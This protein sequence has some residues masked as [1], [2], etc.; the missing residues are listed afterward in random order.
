M[1]RLFVGSLIVFGCYT[2]SV[3]VGSLIT[4]LIGVPTTFISIWAILLI[5]VISSFAAGLSYKISTEEDNE[6]KNPRK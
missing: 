5:L 4:T 3:I 1:H 6:E 2:V